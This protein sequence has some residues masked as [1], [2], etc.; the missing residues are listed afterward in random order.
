MEN[1][2]KKLV[3]KKYYKKVFNK[4]IEKIKKFIKNEENLQGEKVFYLKEKADILFSS[5]FELELSLEPALADF[6]FLSEEKTDDQKI[7]YPLFV[8]DPID[9]SKAFYR[10]SPECCLSVSFFES[11]ED[12]GAHYIWNF[13]NDSLWSYEF[14]SFNFFENYFSSLNVQREQV[15]DLLGAI[16]RTDQSLFC[17]KDSL[18]LF[19][20]DS[21]ALKLAYLSSNHFDFVISKTPKSIWDISAGTMLAKSQG[22]YLYDQFGQALDL[23]SILI[24]GPLIWCKPINFEQIKNLLL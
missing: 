21:I 22:Y 7:L 12:F 1:I 20:M 2:K 23:N 8:I 10:G 15:G 4:S 6:H 16:S 17:R 19:A 11:K 18:S 14:D 3:R 24:K 13:N 9:G 5:F